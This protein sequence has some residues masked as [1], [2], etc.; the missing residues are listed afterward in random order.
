[1]ARTAKAKK[2]EQS[3]LER[4]VARCASFG[5]MPLLFTCDY[6]PYG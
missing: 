4:M 5:S 2:A 3:E 6:V 1:M